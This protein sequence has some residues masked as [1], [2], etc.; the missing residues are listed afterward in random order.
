M[1]ALQTLKAFDIQA[2]DV[3]VWAV[4]KSGGIAGTPPIY[5]AR[6]IQIDPNL[7][8]AL[9]KAVQTARNGVDEIKDYGLL[10]QNNEA[11]AL[12]IA[13]DE[14][15]APLLRAACADPTAQRKVKVLKEISNSAL[16]VIKLVVDGNALMAVRRTD[17]SW[18]S[19]ISTSFVTA[20]F[21]DNILTLDERPRFSI[22]NAVDFFVVDADVLVL[23]KGNFESLLNYREAHVEDFGVLQ[24]EQAFIDIFTALPELVAYVGTNKLQL[25]RASAIKTMGHYRNADFMDR[26]RR[27][28][29]GL[30]LNIT[31]DDAGRIVPTPNSCRDIF[32]AIL[33]HR[34]DSR[35]SQTIY[36]VDDAQPL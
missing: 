20:V 9:K 28:A 17:P 10:A 18:K 34:L 2:A 11:S 14:T 35:L 4:K 15:N 33:D 21:A 27:E 30:H 5:T 8:D 36:D 19:K 22:S 29:A 13:A 32:Q 23:N 1:T 26:L 25:R 24:E 12:L 7:A 31:F 16:Y 3:T 6:W